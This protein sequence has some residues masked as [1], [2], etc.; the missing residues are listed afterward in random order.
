MNYKK[1]SIVI[2]VYFQKVTYML[3]PPEHNIY[4]CILCPYENGEITNIFL[5]C[6][7]CVMYVYSYSIHRK[8]TSCCVLQHILQVQRIILYTKN[9]VCDMGLFTYI[10]DV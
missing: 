5:Y 2:T 9:D 6:F 8:G 7:V 1:S 4:T 10:R 3:F